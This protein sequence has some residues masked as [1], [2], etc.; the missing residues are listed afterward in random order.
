MVFAFDTNHE[1]L[2]AF[3][4]PSELGPKNI[5]QVGYKVHGSALLKYYHINSSVNLTATDNYSLQVQS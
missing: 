1:D 4:S 5:L 2:A 3:T